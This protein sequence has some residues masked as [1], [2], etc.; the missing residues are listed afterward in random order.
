MHSPNEGKRN[1]SLTRIAATARRREGP[2]EA[3]NAVIETR[4]ALGGLLLLFLASLAYVVFGGA[5]ALEA[6]PLAEADARIAAVAVP[7]A[8][9]GGAPRKQK[10]S[11]PF[12]LPGDYFASAYA[13]RGR[14]GDAN[15]MTY[16][17]D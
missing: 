8:D 9:A 3:P 15:R 16:A 10:I 17:H 14:G 7:T 6:S 1:I 13:R 2:D 4:E 5:F 11:G 12:A